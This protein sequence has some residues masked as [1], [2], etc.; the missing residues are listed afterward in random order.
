MLF[1]V[2]LTSYWHQLA[3]VKVLQPALDEEGKRCHEYR[4]IKAQVDWVSDQHLETT[5]S[6]GQVLFSTARIPQVGQTWL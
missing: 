2:L 1:C 3:G 6:S 4:N 5:P